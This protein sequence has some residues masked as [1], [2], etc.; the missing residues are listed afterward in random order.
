MKVNSFSELVKYIRN[1]ILEDG[2]NDLQIT[3][4]DDGIYFSL[5]ELFEVE[6]GI[7][8]E[9]IYTQNLKEYEEKYTAKLKTEFLN[10]DLTTGEL[11]EISK[12]CSFLE[13]N[14]DIIVNLL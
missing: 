5:Y 7:E 3:I 8:K 13:E 2:F 12:V 9:K 11:D 1:D 14:I 4:Y 10:G 6:I